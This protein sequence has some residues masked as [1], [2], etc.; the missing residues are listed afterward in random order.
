MPLLPSVI[1]SDL[2]SDQG[3]W[4]GLPGYSD[5]T[6][7]Y[8]MQTQPST[9]AAAILRKF[10]QYE[11]PPPSVVEATH[12]ISRAFTARGDAFLANGEYHLAISD[13]GDALNHRFAGYLGF[14]YNPEAYCNRYKALHCLAWFFRAKSNPDHPDP[15]M[16]SWARDAVR[17]ARIPHGY[18]V[19]AADENI[20]AHCPLTPEGREEAI[21]F[22]DELADTPDLRFQIDNLYL[23]ESD[24][25]D[26]TVY[27]Y[28][29]TSLEEVHR[30]PARDENGMLIRD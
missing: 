11:D 26:T 13:Y 7:R 4:D 9:L 17:K 1:V 18:L 22:A 6:T 28:D 5:C 25:F 8:I 19:V 27:R 12:Q 3:R 10:L 30:A 23:A 14:Q 2:H 24:E 20:L 29:G 15:D 21:A 16:P